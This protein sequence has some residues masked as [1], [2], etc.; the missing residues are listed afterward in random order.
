VALIIV[1]W[2]PPAAPIG[3]CEPVNRLANAWCPVS[4]TATGFL[5]FI[6]LRAIYNRNRVVIAAFF[7]LWVGLAVGGIFIIVGVKGGPAG[8]TQYCED[9][10]VAGYTFYGEVAP[11]VFDTLVFLAISWR[12][13][14]IAS[15][16]K[17]ANIESMIFGTN[18]PSFTKSLLQDG[19][20][21]Y[22][23]VRFRS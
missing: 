10:F 6:R 23:C 9:V 14:R 17:K 7:V 12:L 11:L 3:N 4:V 21:Y 8:A 19:Q 5:F 22:L 13:S 15:I 20:I 18:L 16:D 1:P 2:I